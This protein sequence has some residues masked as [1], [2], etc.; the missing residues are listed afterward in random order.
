MKRFVVLKVGPHAGDADVVVAIDR[1]V[2]LTRCTHGGTDVH[3]D[4]TAPATF[5]L[6]HDPGEP[7][8]V[9]AAIEERGAE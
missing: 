9:A 8:E 1:I 7:E 4:V 5:R 6:L 3:L 2:A